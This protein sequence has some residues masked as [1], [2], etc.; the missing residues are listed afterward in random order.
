MWGLLE[1]YVC[2]CQTSGFL[3]MYCR[4]CNLLEWI[5]IS[6]RSEISSLRFYCSSRVVFSF[7]LSFA[8]AS[9]TTCTLNIYKSNTVFTW[10]NNVNLP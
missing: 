6:I 2:M 9:G 4:D 8:K 7:A 1:K 5:N 10:E 3:K